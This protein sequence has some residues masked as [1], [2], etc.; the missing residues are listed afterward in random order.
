MQV[1]VVRYLVGGPSVLKAEDL[2]RQN[3]KMARKTD[4]LRLSLDMLQKAH[5]DLVNV[6]RDS[7]CSKVPKIM[8]VSL[9][10]L[11]SRQRIYCSTRCV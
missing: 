1:A 10:A 4:G 7:G 6:L 5:Q 8:R 9:W 3:A 11:G 2:I